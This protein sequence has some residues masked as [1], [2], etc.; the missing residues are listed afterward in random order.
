MNQKQ[1]AILIDSS[2]LLHRAVWIAENV[3]HNVNPSYIFLTSVKKYA[4]MFECTNIYSVWDKRLVRGIKNYRRQAKKVEYKGNRDVEKNAKVFSYEDDTS[5]LLSSVGVKNIYPGILEADDVISWLCSKI[6]GKKVV[7][8]V[9]Q[10][11]LQLVDYKTT[12]YSPIKDIIYDHNNFADKIGV[13]TKQFLRYKSL[14]GDKS[15]NLPGIGKCGPKTAAKLVKKHPTDETLLAELGEK[16]LKP[17]FINL[18]MIDLTEGH[19][20]HPEDVEL[21]NDQYSVLQDH[22]PDFN[23]FKELCES[24]GMR[25]VVGDIHVWKQVF[26]PVDINNTLES[27]VNKLD[28]HK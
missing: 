4:Q 28:I 25:K 27:I 15:D 26:D 18:K 7:V 6:D 24:H 23:V 17:Y 9:D 20:Q 10:D 13:T 21:Y 8:S 11:M 12:V 14:M 22:Q 3:R 1:K 5:E 16:K 19:R 2:N